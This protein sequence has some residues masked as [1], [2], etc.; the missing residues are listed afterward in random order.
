MA[1]IGDVILEQALLGTDPA[2]TGN[3]EHDW[4]PHGCYPCQGSDRWVSIAV[5]SDNEWRRLAD[6]L[7]LDPARRQAWAES[8]V[9]IA[10]RREI[11]DAVGAW[12]VRRTPSEAEDTLQAA[13]VAAVAVFDAADLAADQHMRH[14]GFIVDVPGVDRSWPL[15][16]LGGRL[17]ATPLRAEW[18]GPALGAHNDEVLG[19]LLG[20]S[21]DERLALAEEGVL[22]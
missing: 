13:G 19:D 11:D 21:D 16:Q 8:A 6:V 12:T 7:Q 17:P 5:R 18:A 2:S 20:F 9:R 22:T 1:L 15:V 14:R 3:D 10:A 4:A